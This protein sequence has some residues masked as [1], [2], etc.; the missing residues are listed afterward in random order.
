MHLD[1]DCMDDFRAFTID[2]ERFPKLREFTQEMAA[3]D[4]R[5][6]TII[7]PGVKSENNN[8]LFEEGRAQEVFCKQPNGQPILAPV[9][10]GMCAFPD[11]TDPQA[12][13]WWSRQ[14]AYKKIQLHLHGFELQQA[15]VDGK[16]VDC[17]ENCL[18]VEE[19]EE[20]LFKG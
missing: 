2:P 15:V 18:E 20:V 11:F 14:F 8:K 4:I 3:K 13:H 7:N 10:G 5:L 6:I 19:F 1:I 16:E 12:R 17:E 9:W